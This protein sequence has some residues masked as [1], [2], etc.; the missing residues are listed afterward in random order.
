MSAKSTF[1]PVN[2]AKPP[3][4]VGVDVGGTN[5]KIGLVDD[6]G[7]SLAFVSIPTQSDRGPDDA[8]Q[9]MA[10]AIDSM[11]A[12]AGVDRRE[13]SRVGLAT[14][15]SMDIAAGMLLEPH[16]LPG[17]FNYPIRD[18]LAKASQFPVTFVNDAN[19]AAYGEYW[20]G[21]GKDFH[22]I[23][24]LTLGTGVG[25]G[26]IIGDLLVE[27]EQSAGAECG[28][29]IIDTSPDA[30]VCPCGHLGHLEGYAS[31]TAV[32]ARTREALAEKPATSL[33]ARLE[34]GK[35]LTPLLIA[36]EAE[37]GD[38]FCIEI[39][40]ETARYL[41][42]GIASLLHVIN[43]NGV[44]LGGAMTFGG[45]RSKLGQQFRARVVQEVNARGLS[46]VTKQLTI[47]FASLG[48]DAGYFG[49]AGMARLDHLGKR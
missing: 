3:L 13:V 36:K 7:R 21:R 31:A 12:T 35:R 15:G 26:I 22:S 34:A 32:L 23:I 39:V 19:A 16:N 17:W 42:I 46:S 5:V 29:V 27:G 24:L 9:R 43:P 38:A 33:T 14:P 8:V 11:L 41:G 47:D 44:V 6:A 20:S 30:R 4:F 28:H 37:A 40:M 48:G 10:Q 1:H 25:G 2:Q 49:A 18:S 45:A